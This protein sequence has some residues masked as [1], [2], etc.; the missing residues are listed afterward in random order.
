MDYTDKI[1]DEV[2]R[3]STSTLLLLIDTI[4]SEDA[5]DPADAT[6]YASVTIL[7]PDRFNDFL[8]RG[9][10]RQAAFGFG[11]VRLRPIEQ[12][13]KKTMPTKEP[14]STPSVDNRPSM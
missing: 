2:S 11:F 3:Q 8:L 12:G 7:D 5:S 4:E 10:G 1:R 13:T 14:A 9:I 6:I